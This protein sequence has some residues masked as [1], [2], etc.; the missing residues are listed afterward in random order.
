MNDKVKNIFLA[1]QSNFK[2]GNKNLYFGIVGVVVLIPLTFWLLSSE[3]KQDLTKSFES[4]EQVKPYT[5]P[6]MENPFVMDNLEKDSTIQTEATLRHSEVL[7]E[8][9]QESKRDISAQYDNTKVQN[10]KAKDSKDSTNLN[11][12]LNPNNLAGLEKDKHESK[13]PTMQGGISDNQ[14]DNIKK[15]LKTQKPQNMIAFLKEIQKDCELNKSNLIFKYEG[16]ILKVG[17]KLNNWYAIEEITKNYVRFNATN[18]AYNLRF[19]EE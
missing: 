3:E 16:R 15:I 12:S 1:L 19:L 5:P 2:I 17:D 9:S 4:Q 10:T 18:Y 14:L 13:I 6:K 8:E 11:K 7:A